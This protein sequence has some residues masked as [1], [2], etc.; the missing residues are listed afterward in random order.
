MQIVLPNGVQLD[1]KKYFADELN[2]HIK[3][4][5]LKNCVAFYS[6]FNDYEAYLLVVDNKPFSESQK[7]EDIA[8][9]IDMLALEIEF[10]VTDNV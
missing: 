5:K 2:K 6:K 7:M 9:C 1:D 3:R 8:A 10:G 4:K